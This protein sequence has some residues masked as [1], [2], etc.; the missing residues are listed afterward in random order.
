MN[1]RRPIVVTN[2]ISDHIR[3]IPKNCAIDTRKIVQLIT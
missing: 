1:I 2:V 3:V